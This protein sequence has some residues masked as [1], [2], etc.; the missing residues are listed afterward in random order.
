MICVAY[1]I[2]GA[3]VI[4]SQYNYDRLSQLARHD[5]KLLRR[6]QRAIPLSSGY[7]Q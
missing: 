2:C 6:L 1:T 5:L 4:N 7:Q 3:E